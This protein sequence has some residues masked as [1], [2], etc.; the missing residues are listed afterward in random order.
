MKKPKK[1]SIPKTVP[2]P[3]DL[4]KSPGDPDKSPGALGLSRNRPQVTHGNCRVGRGGGDKF[5]SAMTPRV[6]FLKI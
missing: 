6:I 5:K 1:N 3:G 2:S 4:D